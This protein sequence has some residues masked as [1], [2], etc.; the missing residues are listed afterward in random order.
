MSSAFFEPCLLFVCSSPGGVTSGSDC[1]S[2]RDS[3][4]TEDDLLN[5]R[6]FCGRA[7]VHTDFVPSPYDTESL[8]LKVNMSLYDCNCFILV[9]LECHI[10][11]GLALWGLKCESLSVHRSLQTEIYSNKHLIDCRQSLTLCSLPMAPP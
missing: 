3:L 11:K 5:T 9:R 1:S 8:K 4:R 6:L 7:R 2:N 10:F